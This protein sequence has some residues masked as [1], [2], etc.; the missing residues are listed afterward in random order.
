[1]SDIIFVKKSTQKHQ[2][3]TNLSPSILFHIKKKKLFFTSVQYRISYS[4]S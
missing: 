1:M 3:P 2:T 4:L